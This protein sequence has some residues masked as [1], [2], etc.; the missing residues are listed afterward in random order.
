MH[1]FIHKHTAVR[2]EAF[3]DSPELP[4]SEMIVD[5]GLVDGSEV[6]G[7]APLISLSL[8]LYHIYIYIYICTHIFI[9][10]YIYIYRERGGLICKYV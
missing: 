8:S 6:W 7:V 3:P 2:Q 4:K 1:V 5:L 9:C 10:I